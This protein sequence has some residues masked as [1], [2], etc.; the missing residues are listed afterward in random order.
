MRR[1]DSTGEIAYYRVIRRTR[2]R[3]A[4]WSGSPGN[5]G[6]SRSPSK[7]PRAGPVSTSTRSGTW[8]SW[9]RWT[10]LCMLA[11][12]FLAVVTTAERDRTPTSD[13]MIPYTLNEIRLFD[14]LTIGPATRT[15][16]HILHRSS[17]RRRH[18][19][20]ARECHYRRR[21]KHP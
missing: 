11:M 6:P 2:S 3:S 18:Q 7:P 8:T 19:A 12:A 1:N 20:T 15:H 10:V 21:S 13:G 17:W 9:Q 16:D 5:G 14:A 4:N